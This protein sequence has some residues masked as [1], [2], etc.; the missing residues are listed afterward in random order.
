ME[1]TSATRADFD[2]IY[3]EL[4]KAF[5]LDERRDYEDAL[6]LFNE[7]KYEILLFSLN[8]ED[9]GFITVWRLSNSI[10]FEHFLIYEKHRNNGY[11]AMALRE[12]KKR[13]ERR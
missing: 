7:G 4:V 6:R 8:G 12:L 1:I 10:F 11:G 2:F 9:V 5:I 13:F 3:S